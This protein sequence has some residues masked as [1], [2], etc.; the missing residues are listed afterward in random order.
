MKTM[1]FDDSP[2]HFFRRLRT[3]AV[4]VKRFWLPVVLLIMCGCSQTP[5]DV[6]GPWGGAYDITAV[7]TKVE[8]ELKQDGSRLSGEY[9]AFEPSS[10]F[11]FG[12][13][14]EGH[15]SGSDV[16]LTLQVDQETKEKKRLSDLEFKGV[17][18]E[19]DG[20]LV[21]N[22]WTTSNYNGSKKVMETLFTK[23]SASDE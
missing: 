3:A 10:M 2:V 4:S 6:S 21:I 12:G 14:V 5:R 13:A 20:Q 7:V 11:G 1:F 23:E 15:V 9:S 8:L 18:K 17:V 16:F 22:G 19:E